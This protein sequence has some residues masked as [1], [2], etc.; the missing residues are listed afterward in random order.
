MKAR[1]LR[2]E[3]RSQWMGKRVDGMKGRLCLFWAKW[4]PQGLGHIIL[5]H[6]LH[7]LGTGVKHDHG[8]RT[9]EWGRLQ[10]GPEEV[11]SEVTVMQFSSRHGSSW[12]SRPTG[13]SMSSLHTTPQ[14]PGLHAIPSL[15]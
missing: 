5:A 7:H 14:P 2:C 13:L 6:L 3:E 4:T 11:M 8:S 9:P 10:D 1:W 12:A 15:C